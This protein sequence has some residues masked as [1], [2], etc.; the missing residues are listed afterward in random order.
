MMPMARGV[1]N[2][3]RETLCGRSSI[4]RSQ[5]AGDRP[6]RFASKNEVRRY[7]S[8]SGLETRAIAA[9]QPSRVDHRAG[10]RQ[11][12]RERTRMEY[13]GARCR[14]RRIDG[15]WRTRIG[16]SQAPPR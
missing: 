4:L 16:D 12:R 9:Q 2:V 6:H 11:L 7:G 13:R 3:P 14:S 8:A 15:R 5:T 10:A 1:A